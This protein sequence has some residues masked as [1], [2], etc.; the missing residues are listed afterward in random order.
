MKNLFKWACI[1]GLLALLSACGK[2]V[3]LQ[4]GL[5]DGDANE[6][7][8]IL[9]RKGMEVEKQKNKEGVSLLVKEQ[10]LSRA[11]EAMNV[12]GLPRRALSN[13]GEVFKKQGM[14]STP[15]EERIRYIH[16]LSEEL[17]NTLQQFDNVVS[18]RVHVVLPER[19]APGEPIQPS[20]AAVFVKYRPPLDE[21][22]IM[23]RVR[24]LVASS[25][26]GLSGD[27]G[28]NKVSVVM[29]PAEPP[30]PGIEWT[31]VG[32]FIVAVA[33]AGDLMFT[34]LAMTLLTLLCLGYVGLRAAMRNEK[35]AQWVMQLTMRW[36]A[37]RAAAR[38]KAVAKAAARTAAAAQS[39]M[40]TMPKA[41]PA[42]TSPP[43]SATPPKS[44]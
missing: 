42:G 33:S 20:S 44:R 23:P 24:R 6:I 11:T 40:A 27:E 19:I 1:F 32:P 4:A 30:P 22:A 21:D 25:I 2:M 34:L 9:N 10:D 16:G 36:A 13:L 28:R 43:S 12:A 15:M 37:N 39:L 3:I 5:T 38:E 7:V 26:P 35:V 8:L 41:T 17:E 14:I 29:V 31:T 18:A